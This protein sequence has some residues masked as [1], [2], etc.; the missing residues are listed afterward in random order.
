MYWKIFICLIMV[1]F[2]GISNVCSYSQEV[3][4]HDSVMVIQK[5]NFCLSN[6]RVIFEKGMNVK[7]DTLV[8]INLHLI[9]D[10]PIV[11]SSMPISLFYIKEN[12][13]CQVS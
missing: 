11:R 10:I 2:P 6:D 12:T 1:L 7:A 13:A 8:R 3:R 9:T 4:V 5:G